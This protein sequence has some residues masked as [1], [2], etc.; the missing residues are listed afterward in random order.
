MVVIMCKAARCFVPVLVLALVTACGNSDSEGSKPLASGGSGASGA[1]GSEGGAG[2]SGGTGNAP[3]GGPLAT[4]PFDYLDCVSVP[5]APAQPPGGGTDIASGNLS[6][7]ASGEGYTGSF[8]T[9]DVVDQAF[10]AARRGTITGTPPDPWNAQFRKS[11]TG[12]IAAG[13]ILLADFWVRCE[14]TLAES[15]ECQLLFVIEDT[16]SYAKAVQ[17]PVRVGKDWVHFY[18]PIT[19]PQA[20]AVDG[21]GIALFAGYADQTADVGPFHVTNYGT[22]VSA[23]ELP[24]TAVTYPGVDADAPWRAAASERIDEHRRSDLVVAV[25]DADGEPLPDASVHVQMKRHEFLFGSAISSGIVAMGEEPDQYDRYETEVTRLFNVVTAYNAFKW[26]PWEGDW[27]GAWTQQRAVDTLAWAED[28]EI[29]FRGHVLVWPSWG[30]LPTR[31][32]ALQ[33]DPDALRQEVLDHIDDAMALTQGRLIQW[34]VVNEPY[35]NRDLMDILGDDVVV[36]WFERARTG[37]PDVQL[38]LNDYAILTGG[39]GDTGHRDDFEQWIELLTSANAPLDGL[40]MQSHFGLALTGPDD[41]LE[42]LDRYGTTYD[43]DVAITEYDID[44]DD[45]NLAGCFT[46]DF[47]TTIF[48]HPKTTT[49]VMWG[50]WGDE[51]PLFAPDWTQKMAGRV[52]EDLVF[53][54]WWTDETLTSDATG[55][56]TVRAFHGTYEITV[57]AGDESVT[58][59]VEHSGAAPGNVTI[60]MP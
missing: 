54:R 40:G 12:A 57:T 18:V 48:S 56:A 26:K 1:T 44:V 6:T 28:R 58:E 43:K 36:D 41:I 29:P 17:Y 10:T 50:F 53:R 38:F 35:D 27:G 49:F 55:S 23:D 7:F 13:D 19:A 45:E 31:L 3:T 34:D 32:E 5:S 33:D 11:N 46:H 47:M 15:N 37:D 25:T 52:F 30:H 4:T 21:A 39:G 51:D 20:Y 60:A 24:S 42:L 16:T 9:V 8:T 59:T 22:S 14:K 2:A